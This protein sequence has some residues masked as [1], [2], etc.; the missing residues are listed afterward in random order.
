MTGLIQRLPTD[1][2]SYLLWY[3]LPKGQNI[4]VGKFGPQLFKRG[5][6][7]YCGSAFGSG[8]LRGRLKHHLAQSEKC[9][10]H[11]DY[12]KAHA[13]L[14]RLWIHVGYNK[15][16]DWSR[17]LLFDCGGQVLC[18]GFGSSDCSCDS[19]LIY[20]SSQAAIAIA[21]SKISSTDIIKCYRC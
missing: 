10:W 4:S 11:I 14:R 15:E 20:F 9:H 12:F 21:G 19:H 16:H 18:R 3:F 2:G 1:P 6:Y 5:W 13:S 17:L 7:G 8:G